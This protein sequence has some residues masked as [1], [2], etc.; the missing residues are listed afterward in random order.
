MFITFLPWQ[1][2]VQDFQDFTY[3]K[4]GYVNAARSLLTLDKNRR[5][6]CTCMMHV[7]NSNYFSPE[8]PNGNGPRD[9][10]IQASSSAHQSVLMYLSMWEGAGPGVF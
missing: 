9:Q 1:K 2:C 10:A 7:Q 3:F 5:L 6:T 4:F 8:K